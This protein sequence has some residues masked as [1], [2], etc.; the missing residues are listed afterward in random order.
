MDLTLVDLLIY[1][2]YCKN[3]EK[4]INDNIE[5]IT[6]DLKSLSVFAPTKKY[7]K[8]LL[9]EQKKELEIIKTKKTLCIN[10]ITKYSTISSD[11]LLPFLTEYISKKE[12]EQYILL[13]EVEERC[14][15][16]TPFNIFGNSYNII[17]V[18]KNKD[19]FKTFNL[20][21]V[22]NRCICLDADKDEYSL[23]SGTS[24]APEFEKFPYLRKLAFD[25]VNLKLQDKTLSDVERLEIISGNKIQK[26]KEK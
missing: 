3:K 23:L 9:K 22:N 1:I 17:T 19:K 14:S 15:N 25:L 20:Y 10:K 18:L 6:T 2:E 11:A 21:N 8:E 7:F 4:N 26:T 24:L 16:K 13:E 12:K 5:R